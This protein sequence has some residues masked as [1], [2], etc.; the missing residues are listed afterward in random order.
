VYQSSFTI[1]KVAQNIPREIMKQETSFDAQLTSQLK[2]IL[3]RAN[4]D[5]FV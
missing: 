1:L 2:S 4:D 5:M 3:W